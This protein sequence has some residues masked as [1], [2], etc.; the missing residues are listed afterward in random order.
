MTDD[1]FPYY[2]SNVKAKKVTCHPFSNMKIKTVL[3]PYHKKTCFIHSA[4]KSQMHGIL[5]RG[6]NTKNEQPS[7][8]TVIMDDTLLINV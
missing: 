2:L 1:Y 7:T 5:E 4:V 3:H 6:T 8:D